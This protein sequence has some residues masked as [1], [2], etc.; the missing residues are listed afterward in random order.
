[1]TDRE[2]MQQALEALEGL[3]DISWSEAFKQRKYDSDEPEENIQRECVLG[4]ITALRERLAQPTLQE[5]VVMRERSC[6]ECGKSGGWA[7]YCV[8]CMEKLSRREWVGL[9]EE[10]MVMCESEED[11]RFVRAIEAKLKE[12][13]A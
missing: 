5:A 12:R 6:A 13:N 9:T 11:V 3:A 8:A 2:L 4:A 10:E 1:M 7:L